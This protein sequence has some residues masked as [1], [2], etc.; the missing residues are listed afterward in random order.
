MPVAVDNGGED[1]EAE[2]QFLEEVSKV[3]VVEGGDGTPVLVPKAPICNEGP[4]A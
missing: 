3:H 1:E 2:L 4:R